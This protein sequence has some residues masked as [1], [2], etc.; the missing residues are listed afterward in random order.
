MNEYDEIAKKAGA[1]HVLWRDDSPI[2]YY[3]DGLYEISMVFLDKHIVANRGRR[4]DPRIVNQYHR[5]E[6]SC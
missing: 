4:W 6:L 2:V 1:T 3:M 5:R